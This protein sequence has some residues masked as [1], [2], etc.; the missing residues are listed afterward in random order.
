MIEMDWIDMKDSK[1]SILIESIIGLDEN[2]MARA[3]SY[4][5]DNK[6]TSRGKEYIITKYQILTLYL[7][8]ISNLGFDYWIDKHI[9]IHLISDMDDEYLYNIV[10]MKDIDIDDM[11]KIRIPYVEAELRKR[12]LEQ[13]INL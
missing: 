11:F 9:N 5:G 7:S 4:I 10:K 12:K 13:I 8:K 6:M 3:G 1:P 2:D